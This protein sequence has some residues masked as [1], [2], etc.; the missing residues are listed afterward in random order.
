[1]QAG[2]D[3]PWP[4]LAG[5]SA[6]LALAGDAGDLAVEM[7]SAGAPSLTLVGRVN[8]LHPMLPFSAVLRATAD[9]PLP[10]GELF[11]LPPSL[12][13][14]AM[15]FPLQLSARGD[16]GEQALTLRLQAQL[17][18]YERLTIR[19]DAQNNPTA[20]R[21]EQLVVSDEA[22]A[23]RLQAEGEIRW[24]ENL[25][26]SV[27]ASSS[28]LSLPPLHPLLAGRVSG[29][30]ASSGEIGSDHYRISLWDMD[31][32]GEVNQ[33]PAMLSGA[34]AIGDG[35]LLPQSELRAK[36]NDARLTLT[37]GDSGSVLALHV[38]DLG[39]WQA[40]AGGTL[41]ATAKLRDMAKRITLDAELADVHY[42]AVQVAAGSLQA[43]LDRT[44]NDAF[45]GR[46]HLTRVA[47]Q[48]QSL[49]ALTVS[50]QGDA[51]NQRL[52]LD[53]SGFVTGALQLSGA[54][55][56]TLWEGNLAATALQFGE[57]RW[58]L[59]NPVALRAVDGSLEIAGHCWRHAWA[60]VCPG[61][62]QLGRSGGGDMEFD[63]DLA[64][65]A[66]L[67]PQRSALDGKLA[68]STALRWTDA[69]ELS[70][71]ATLRAGPLSVTERLPEGERVE[72][73]ARSLH[74]DARYAEGELA[75]QASLLPDSG[76]EL[77]LDLRMPPAPDAPLSGELRIDNM[78]L[79]GFDALLPQLADLE[80]RVDGLLRLSGSAAQPL[81]HGRLRISDGM[82]ALPASPTRLGAL[83]MQI[84]AAGDSLSL[85]A[86]A[87]LGDG[88]VSLRGEVTSAP[89]MQWRLQLRGDNNQL[90]YPP[91]TMLQLS[92]SLDITGSGERVSVEG[93]VVVHSGE[94]RIQQL[95]EGGV[96][97]SADVVQVDSSGQVL[98]E[99]SPL[100]IDSN[101]RVRVEDG[102]RLTGDM[103]DTALAGE[104]QL[105]RRSR[106]PLQVFGSLETTGGYVTAYERVLQ[107]QRG[108]VSFSGAPDNPL[109]DL[110]AERRISGEN[111]T[112]GIHVHGELARDLAL[113]V[114]AD[115]P[116]SQGDAMSYLIW[117]RSLDSGTNTDGAVLAL[118]LA[119][120]VVNRSSLVRNINRVPGISNVTFGAQ[121][122]EADAAATV[123]GYIGEK[124]YLSYG[125]G[126]Y[127]PVNVLTARLFL[128]TRLW[129]EVVSRLEN[130]LDLYYSFDID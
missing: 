34:I 25:S 1:L 4:P 104:L 70:G 98:N 118:S 97:L 18:G 40:G 124:L 123:S 99:T 95:P 89:Q 127:E 72:L 73:R 115:P 103:L 8:T 82:L 17:P 7:T 122:S 107:I 117:G 84:D 85:N 105:R 23:T 79:A 92:P 28:G 68:A 81:T 87:T 20:L 14:S 66:P 96:E 57:Q 11:D 116:M 71:T 10:L 65:L 53:S 69:G 100:A 108:V 49:D 19:L 42:N 47:W 21:I 126:L 94:L 61:N 62:W 24:R 31:L 50:V 67:L 120:G 109:L 59:G 29:S 37:P 27:S 113:D 22:S 102:F 74:A 38:D 54:R 111:I 76:G 129:L 15:L 43:Q 110:R 36:V 75:L 39:R 3:A 45:S 56:D 30:L 101:V 41:S 44:A 130:S 52:Q 55:Q 58:T 83:D 16:A 128:Q 112:A 9:A 48:A 88:P 60:R 33:L 114:Y 90:L 77:T 80:G 51:E 32:E 93:E 35:A 86:T 106:E 119:S 5:R 46:L 125:F 12:T 13:N 78:L 121:G 6:S 2:P 26:W 64:L 91:S 63:G